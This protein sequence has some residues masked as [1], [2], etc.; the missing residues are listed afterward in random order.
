MELDISIDEYIQCNKTKEWRANNVQYEKKT[1]ERRGEERWLELRHE[2]RL[3]E[4]SHSL[5]VMV[6]PGAASHRLQ[7]EHQQAV[8]PG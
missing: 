6:R 2:L 3:R 7:E 5:S 8:W 4:A 1:W